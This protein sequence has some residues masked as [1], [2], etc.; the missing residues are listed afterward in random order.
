[1]WTPVSTTSACDAAS[2]AA[3]R[4]RASGA[5]ER[6]SPRASTVAQNVQCSSQ[7]SWTLSHARDPDAKCR[8]SSPPP[9]PPRPA[10]TPSA[11]ATRAPSA[12]STTA[13]TFG[14]AAIRPS[15]SAAAHPITTVRIAGV[16]RARRRTSARIFASPTC[17]TA[18]ELTTAAS[19]PSGE[20]TARQPASSSRCRTTSV[21]Y[22][23]AL[24]PN[25]W[26]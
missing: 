24:Q 18:H 6:A 10:A 21:S 16:R 17:V 1:M 19:A 9:S 26:K 2:C 3:S 12:P 14:S 25:V 8:S 15:S 23:F 20:A 22:W 7:P 13:A 5:R 4:T 11:P